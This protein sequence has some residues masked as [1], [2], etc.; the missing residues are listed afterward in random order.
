MNRIK[1]TRYTRIYLYILGVYDIDSAHKTSEFGPRDWCCNNKRDKLAR[2]VVSLTFR[3]ITNA[4]TNSGERRSLSV[5]RDI[6]LIS[7][8]ADNK[9][10]TSRY[11]FFENN[12]FDSGIRE[13]LYRSYSQNFKYVRSDY[14]ITDF[15]RLRKREREKK[16]MAKN[17][18]HFLA[19]RA[20]VVASFNT[21]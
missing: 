4:K 3:L 14:S 7:P 16:E 8:D 13:A 21:R 11:G 18:Y 9:K 20:R 19:L 15:V 6:I 12:K 10:I 5:Q 17:F 2:V 1:K